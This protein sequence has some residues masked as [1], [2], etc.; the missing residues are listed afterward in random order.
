MKPFCE[1]NTVEL[2]NDH[3]FIKTTPLK[4]A[5]LLNMELLLIFIIKS[6]SITFGHAQIY[7]PSF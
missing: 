7:T 3:P 4:N 1:Y 2:L 6:A 5:D